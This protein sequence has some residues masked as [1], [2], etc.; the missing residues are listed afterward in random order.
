[1]SDVD[2]GSMNEQHAR[3]AL[4]LDHGEANDL[5]STAPNARKRPRG[6]PFAKGNPGRPVGLR[7]RRTLAAEALLDGEAEVITRKCIEL[8]KA[9]DTFCIKLV[10]ER[11]VPPRKELP[12]QFTLPPLQ[13]GSDL[14]AAMAAILK[15]V[16]DGKILLGQALEFAKLLEAYGRTASASD[17]DDL[18]NLTDE[19][20]RSRI[21]RAQAKVAAIDIDWVEAAGPQAD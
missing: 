6:R 21:L 5:R 12:I 17:P 18:S 7:H 10:L 11:L 19:A 9:G 15:A 20:L 2:T 13:S 1:M 3:H 8:A 16:A 4:G 14:T